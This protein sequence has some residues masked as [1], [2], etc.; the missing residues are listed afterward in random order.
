MS[1][2]KGKKADFIIIDELPTD[3][4]IH[5]SPV[6]PT[7]PPIF[8]IEGHHVHQMGRGMDTGEEIGESGGEGTGKIAIQV[9]TDGIH[10]VISSNGSE[11]E[12]YDI[13]RRKPVRDVPMKDRYPKRMSLEEMREWLAKGCPQE[14]P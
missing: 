3:C 10:I 5:P 7:G 12:I 14:G 2:V 13:Q 6:G 11:T 8:G 4:H 9:T 1:G